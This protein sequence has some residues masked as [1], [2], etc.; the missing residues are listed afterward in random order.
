MLPISRIPESLRTSDAEIQECRQ[1]VARGA[2]PFMISLYS[3]SFSSQ[4]GIAAQADE[5]RFEDFS[6]L[7]MKKGDI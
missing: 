3:L 7:A 6:G 2:T 1:L 4:D 5:G